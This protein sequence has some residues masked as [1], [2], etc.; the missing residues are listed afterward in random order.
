MKLV[1]IIIPVYNRVQLIGET[2]NSILN[3]THNNW[4]CIVVDDGS[5]DDTIRVVKQ[6]NQKDSRIKLYNRP[7]KYIKGANACRNYGFEKSNGDY[8]NWFDSD[9]I[10]MSNFIEK[11]VTILEKEP[12]DFVVSHSVNF[13]EHNQES[14]IFDK[15]NKGKEINA[16][17][18]ISNVINWITMDVMVTRQSV[19]DLRFN[20]KLQSGQEYNFYSRYLLNK[21]KGK[22]IFECLS[23]RRIHNTSIQQELQ[24]DQIKQKKELLFNEIVLLNDI[25]GKVSRSLIKR[26]LKRLIRFNYQTQKKFTIN[27]LQFTVLKELIRFGNLKVICSYALWIIT[28]F[29]F[30]KGYFWIKLSK[31]D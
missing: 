10:M 2:L 5:T 12:L 30:G 8:I 28:N 9:D 6:Y 15:E 25:K 1:S 14:E 3:Q 26:S 27:K 20:E 22:F 7:E 23:K 16:E 29:I 24:K 17:N 19:G 4:E 18:F 13:N 11:K 21:P 31:F